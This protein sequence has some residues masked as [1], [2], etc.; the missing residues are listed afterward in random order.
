MLDTK[1]N[2]WRCIFIMDKYSVEQKLGIIHMYLDSNESFRQI[3]NYYG[4]NKSIIQRWVT[5]Y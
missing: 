5:R 4:I 2:I 3:D 1:I